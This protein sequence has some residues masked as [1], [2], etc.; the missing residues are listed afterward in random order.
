MSEL[1]LLVGSL[2]IADPDSIERNTKG[3][4]ICPDLLLVSDKRYGSCDLLVCDLPCGTDCSR[5]ETLG[6]NKVLSG[7]LCQSLHLFSE[8]HIQI[9][10]GWISPLKDNITKHEMS[11]GRMWY[12]TRYAHR[13]FHHQAPG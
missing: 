10:L 1:S 4:G 12:H 3:S 9:S 8:C 6:K 5:L 11:E 13:R 2:R 7:S